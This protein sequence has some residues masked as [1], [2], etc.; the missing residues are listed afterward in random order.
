LWPPHPLLRNALSHE[1]RGE[2]RCSGLTL[3]S[4]KGLKV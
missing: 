3:I 4:Y 1:W 2:N